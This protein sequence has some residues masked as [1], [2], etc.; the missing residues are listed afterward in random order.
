MYN[1]NTRLRV[2]R[3]NEEGDVVRRIRAFVDRFDS[4]GTEL[5]SPTQEEFFGTE[6]DFQSQM[7]QRFVDAMQQIIPYVHELKGKPFSMHMLSKASGL[8]VFDLYDMV[9]QNI[10]KSPRALICSQRLQ[11]V[12]EML[13]DTDKSVETISQ[14][15]GFV[16]PNYMIS[17]FFHKY[18]VL[19]VDYRAA[20]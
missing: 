3:N 14:E 18:R 1:R 9:S 17:K 7:D 13:R 11:K 8:E 15:C 5:M 19:P 4:Y 10:H 12:A 20:R 16:S 6:R 2:R